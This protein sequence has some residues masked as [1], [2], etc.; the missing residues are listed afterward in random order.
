MLYIKRQFIEFENWKF[1]LLAFY[2][3]IDFNLIKDNLMYK[4]TVTLQC[5]I[6]RGYMDTFYNI[7]NLINPLE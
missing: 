1:I 6:L 3:Y 2:F 5:D 4:R 7:D